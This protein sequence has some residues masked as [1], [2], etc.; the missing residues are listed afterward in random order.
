M[1]IKGSE[2]IRGWEQFEGSIWRVVLPN[3]FFGDFNPYR[4]EIFGD[5]FATTNTGRPKHLGDVYLNGISF[6]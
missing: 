4:E 6:L 2:Q 1:I 3:G 5:W